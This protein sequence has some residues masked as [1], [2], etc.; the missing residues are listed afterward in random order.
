MLTNKTEKNDFKLAGQAIELLEKQLAEW[1]FLKE[2]YEKLSG[3]V[4]KEIRYEDYKFIALH[5]PGRIKSTAADVSDS[6]IK[7]RKCFLCKENLPEKQRGIVY[8]KKYNLL[9]NPYPVAGKHYTIVKL[10]HMPQQIVGNIEDLLDLTRQMSKYF[11]L[12]YNGPKCGA[13]APDHMHFQAVEKM[14][15]PL[16]ND[17][18]KLIN[19]SRN[20]RIDKSRISITAAETYPAKPVIVESEH[21]G[22]I[23]KAFRTILNALKK[24]YEPKEEPMI[25]IV[26][27][28]EGNKWSLFIFP[29]KEHRPKEFYSGELIVSPAALDMAGL[30]VFPR[31]EDFDKI[32]RDKLI[33]IYKQVSFTKEYYEFLKKKLFEK[34]IGV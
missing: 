20:F 10:K 24:I 16:E 28:Y 6:G 9:C 11:T 7:N 33:D 34:Y 13:S 2:N 19:D 4:S 17:Y 14:K 31:K 12:F 22:E 23:L 8:N 1:E 32:D 15:M 30:F 18:K 26:S 29:R 25:N 27:T 5:N 3:I 21:K